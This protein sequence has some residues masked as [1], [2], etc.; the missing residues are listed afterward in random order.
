MNGFEQPRKPSNRVLAATRA[1]QIRRQRLAEAREREAR[2]EQT[3][4]DILAAKFAISEAH[5][6]IAEGVR[7]LKLLGETQDSIAGL[8]ELS[9]GEVR[10]ASAFARE[11]T[12]T[13]EPKA[14]TAPI[15]TLNDE[16]ARDAH[17]E[18]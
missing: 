18:R 2:I 16:E 5:L 13:T 15:R 3:V 8:C 7:Q 17:G 12:P 9:I 4:V 10:A 14:I 1:G 6:T 11:H